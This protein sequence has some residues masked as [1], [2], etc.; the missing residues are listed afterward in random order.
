[1]TTFPVPPIQRVMA[2]LGRHS[3][4]LGT[5]KQNIV[6]L[7]SGLSAATPQPFTP[8]EL[9]NGW[10]NVAGYIPAQ[11]R[12]FAAGTIEVI[13]VIGGGNIANGTVIATLPSG[14]CNTVHEWPFDATILEGATAA[15]DDT[16][17]VVATTT[18]ALTVSGLP[19]G[20]TQISFHEFLPL[21]A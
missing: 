6:T 3:S 10:N 11:W 21:T 5:V 20:T 15:P 9:E 17:L 18:G 14:S 16:P 19:S 1:M 7:K 12:Q 2:M 13:G 4:D 8:L